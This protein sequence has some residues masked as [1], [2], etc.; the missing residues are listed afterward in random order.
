M[1]TLLCRIVAADDK[2]TSLEL[3]QAPNYLGATQYDKGIVGTMIIA[4]L[5]IADE[6][7]TASEAVSKNDVMISEKIV[8]GLVHEARRAI[9]T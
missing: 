3:L 4:K 2:T 8:S 1:D 7:S 6:D 9:G 5:L